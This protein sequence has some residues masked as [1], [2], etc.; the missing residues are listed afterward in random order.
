M[1]NYQ[2]AYH[3]LFDSRIGREYLPMV[4]EFAAARAEFSAMDA[5]NYVCNQR[6]VA[7]SWNVLNALDHLVS[8][9]EI[10]DLTAGA[11]VFGQERRY[12]RL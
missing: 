11:N 9:A 2:D 1:P 3:E 7:D 5:I 6:G 8:M 10:R 4:R 12:Q